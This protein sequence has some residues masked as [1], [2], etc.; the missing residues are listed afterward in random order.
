MTKR[1]KKRRAHTAR[2][3]VSPGSAAHLA[4]P[5]D[6]NVRR[7]PDEIYGDTEIPFRK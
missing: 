3:V 6:E 2:P 1:R 7:H 4:L 5:P